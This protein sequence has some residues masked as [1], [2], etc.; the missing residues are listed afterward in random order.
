M[1]DLVLPR[2]D[3]AC[4]TILAGPGALPPALKTLDGDSW[5]GW[6]LTTNGAHAVRLCEGSLAITDPGSAQGSHVDLTTVYELRLWDNR[7]AQSSSASSAETRVRAPGSGPCG[8]DG[9]GSDGNSAV[10]ADELRWVN[11]YGSRRVA[12]LAIAKVSR[13]DAEEQ[14]LVRPSTARTHDRRTLG[15][16]EVFR[17]EPQYG[18]VEYLDQIVTGEIS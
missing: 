3:Q 18:N 6:A 16:L 15:L 5:R 13:A 8:A 14:C 17:V 12:V 4:W 9:P 1:P 10:L 7:C 2:L 11:G